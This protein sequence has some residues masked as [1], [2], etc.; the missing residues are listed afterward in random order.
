MESLGGYLEMPV[1]ID[2]DEVVRETKLAWCVRIAR[3]EVWLP[4]AITDLD[5]VTQVV[6]M[7]EWLAADKG[8]I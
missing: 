1:E 4:K 8:L 5:K 6:T 2:F 7:P 3:I